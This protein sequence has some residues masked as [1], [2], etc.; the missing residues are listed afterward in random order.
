MPFMVR[1]GVRFS[2]LDS[3]SGP[4][5]VFQHGLGGDMSQPV[6]L[7]Q[8]RPRRRLV[9]LECR[10]H[11]DT[12][13]L[14]P[15]D[16]LSFASFAA[17]LLALLDH[18]NAGSVLLGGVSMGAGVALRLAAEH[19]ERVSGLVLLRP[20]WFDAPWPEHLRIFDLVAE[21]LQQADG[22]R[23]KAL[24]RE[25]EQ[26]QVI[27]RQSTAV[28]ESRLSQFD[29]PFARERAPVLR[30]LPGDYPLAGG[31]SW[32]A[33][34]APTLVLGTR[35]DPQHPLAIAE[36]IASAL[37]QAILREVTPKGVDRARHSRDVAAATEDFTAA[38]ARPTLRL[39]AATRDAARRS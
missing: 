12:Q 28:A 6:E 8:S 34:T 11:G 18:L 24:L 1:D 38:L 2:Y 14:G 27:A 7:F 22:E 5:F 3:G 35:E 39:R 32:T 16:G 20:S 33:I 19:P 13:P 26:Y 36:A 21:M 15:I 10:G 31:L 9:C 29:R 23:G 37:R 30:R 25:T 4:P 17:D